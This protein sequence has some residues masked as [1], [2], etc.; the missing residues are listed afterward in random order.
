MKRN[1]I[2]TTIGT[3]D[4]NDIE[5]CENTLVCCIIDK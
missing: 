5:F 3:I 1:Q 2:T 4:L